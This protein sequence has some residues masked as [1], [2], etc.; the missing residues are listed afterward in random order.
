MIQ[1]SKGTFIEVLNFNKLDNFSPQTFVYSL[2]IK[3]CVGFIDLKDLISQTLLNLI[4]R[5]HFIVP[6]GKFVLD[7]V[8]QSVASQHKRLTEK[9]KF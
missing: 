7:K 2:I 5:M 1:S 3:K 9:K 8:L 4:D 6:E